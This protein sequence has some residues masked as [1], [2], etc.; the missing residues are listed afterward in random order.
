MR[1]AVLGCGN[2][3]SAI[4]K[5]IQ[6]KYD[7]EIVAYDPYKPH[8]DAL[9]N[10]TYMEPQDWFTTSIDVVLLSVKPQIMGEALK[11]FT[12]TEDTTLWVSIAAGVTLAQLTNLLPHNSKICRVMPNTPALIGEGMAGYTLSSLCNSDDEKKV[13]ALLSSIGKYIRVP[14][15]QMDAV[16]GVSGSGPAYIYTIIEALTEGGVVAGLPYKDAQTA[17]IQTIIGAAKMVE[18]SGESP[19]VL[20][21]HVMSPGGTTAAAIKALEEGGLRAAVMNAVVSAAERSKELGKN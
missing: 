18:A 14:E 1:V 7:W 17:A 9:D 21:S 20:K 2:M 3:G 10:V 19:A 11:V 15:Y 5:G 6:K 13:T 12:T 16:V 8:V 4:I